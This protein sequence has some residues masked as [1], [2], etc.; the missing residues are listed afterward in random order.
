MRSS[1]NNDETEETGTEN[2]QPVSLVSKNT[3]EKR[4]G[5]RFASFKLIGA[6]WIPGAI[7]FEM[8]NSAWLGFGVGSPGIPKNKL[9]CYFRHGIYAKIASPTLHMSQ[10]GPTLSDCPTLSPDPAQSKVQ[11]N[12]NG[13]I[14][15]YT[16][17][18]VLAD[19]S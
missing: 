16:I 13:T 14:P 19:E 12:R 1:K 4:G 7:Y 18:S 15:R 2:G 9:L 10:D 5:N 8:K 3:S 6:I 11:A 17:Q